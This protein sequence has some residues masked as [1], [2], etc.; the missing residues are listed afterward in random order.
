VLYCQGFNFIGAYFLTGSYSEQEAF[1]L[2]VHLIENILPMG[3]YTDM[4]AVICFSSVIRDLIEEV[5]P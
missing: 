2:M 5:L 4:S 1:W 3:Y